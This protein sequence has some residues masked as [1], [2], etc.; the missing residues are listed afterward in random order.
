MQNPMLLRNGTAVNGPFQHNNKSLFNFFYR[1]LALLLLTLY[2]T[3][4]LSSD[5]YQ[6][7]YFESQLGHFKELTLGQYVDNN[8]KRIFKWVK[9]VNI[10]VNGDIPSS[11]SS[12]IDLLIVE[13][14]KIVSNVEFKIVISEEQANYFIFLGE[15]K[16]YVNFEP[17]MTLDDLKSGGSF[18]LYPNS[19]YEIVNGSMY[20]DIARYKNSTVRK[21]ILRK[22]LTRSLGIPYESRNHEY[23]DSIFSGARYRKLIVSYSN[24]DKKIIRKLY[25]EC[26]KAGMDKFE[27]D[28]ALLNGC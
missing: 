1:L 17:N 7:E 8:D 20:I 24:F 5:K 19:D 6:Y 28:N 25:S 26:V 2:I 9:D 21:H 3:P 11:L 18:Y 16:E 15:A 10:F 14:N 27:L 4:A 23:A 12:E 22:L 13:I